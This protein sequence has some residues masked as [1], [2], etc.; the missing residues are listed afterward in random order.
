M[1]KEDILTL[2]QVAELLKIS[3]LTVHRLTQKGALPGSKI[4]SQWRYWRANIEALL[5]HP[6]MSSRMNNTQRI[7]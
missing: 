4:G 1:D 6:R 3:P 5:K 2:K 7:G